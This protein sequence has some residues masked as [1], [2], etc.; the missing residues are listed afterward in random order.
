MFQGADKAFQPPIQ[1]ANCMVTR[2][3]QE[4]NLSVH[5]DCLKPSAH[6]VWV[7]QPGLKF[8]KFLDPQTHGRQT[9]VTWDH[10]QVAG[11]IDPWPLSLG[12]PLAN[13]QYNTTIPPPL[14]P[15]KYPH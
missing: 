11:L 13:T 1:L 5:Y 12:N 7:S 15:E 2:P 14:K 10:L 9:T 8:A 6:W 3:I 4:T